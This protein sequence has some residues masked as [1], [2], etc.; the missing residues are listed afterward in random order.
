MSTT[1]CTTTLAPF[2]PDTVI[3][4]VAVP[5]GACCQ[6]TLTVARA[7]LSTVPWSGVTCS[8]GCA[9]VMLY[10]NGVEPRLKTSMY[11]PGCAWYGLKLGSTAGPVSCGH[12]LSD[13][14]I[15]TPMSAPAGGSYCFS[16]GKM[17][18]GSAT[19]LSSGCCH[20]ALGPYLA[21]SP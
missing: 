10:A 16:A 8:H 11:C 13:P 2:G 7:C 21:T 20:G 19:L 15:A 6:S 18:S 12:H 1:A 14:S 5:F 17:T 9:A 3:G 4:T